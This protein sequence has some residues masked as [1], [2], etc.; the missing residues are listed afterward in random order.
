MRTRAVQISFV[1]LEQNF[2]HRIR[3][4]YVGSDQLEDK[5]AIA[6]GIIREIDQTV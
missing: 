3:M 5:A 4:S 6:D 1:L 2:K